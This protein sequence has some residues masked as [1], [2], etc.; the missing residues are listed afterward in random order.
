MRGAYSFARVL[1][2]AQQEEEPA[3]RVT[4]IM[5]IL[6]H[7]QQDVEMFPIDVNQIES[8]LFTWV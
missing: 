5:L 8:W 4:E 1:F 6:K 7:S 2:S 3:R